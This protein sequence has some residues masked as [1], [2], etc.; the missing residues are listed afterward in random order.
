MSCPN[1]R[2]NRSLPKAVSSVL[3]I[4]TKLRSQQKLLSQVRSLITF[5]LDSTIIDNDNN[6]KDNVNH[7]NCLWI[8][9]KEHWLYISL[10]PIVLFRSISCICSRCDIVKHFTIVLLYLFYLYVN[11]EVI[12]VYFI[13]FNEGSESFLI[14]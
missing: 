11:L 1:F 2:I 12:F 8:T 13:S 7:D 6:I 10:D 5:I 3:K 9:G 4:K 14:F